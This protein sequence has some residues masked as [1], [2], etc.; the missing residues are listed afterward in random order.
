MTPPGDTR[1]GDEPDEA[2]R[3]A[4]PAFARHFLPVHLRRTHGAEGAAESEQVVLC[5]THSR[6]VPVSD[7]LDCDHRL[8]IDASDRDGMVLI[9]DGDHSGAELDEVAAEQDATSLAPL[10]VPIGT[11]MSRLVECVTPDVTIEHLARILL[12]HGY[13]GL[14]VVDQHGRPIGVASKAD[15][16]RHLQA[17]ADP[18]ESLPLVVD[19]APG[20]SFELGAGYRRDAL[21]RG[22]VRDIMTPLA[23]SMPADATVGRA[24][25]L[26]AFEGV[27]RVPVTDA[28]GCVVGLLSS[29]DVLRWLGRCAGYML[30]DRSEASVPPPDR[31]AK[32]VP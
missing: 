12:V 29:L 10:T 4:G 26:M 17:N 27:H 8:G 13:G 6:Y 31:E 25:A 22:T 11:I 20:V 2:A 7:C 23:L 14:P 19:G 32:S 9:C 24:A 28:G 1:R 16:L 30:P 15:L 21:R 18:D 3:T 5:A